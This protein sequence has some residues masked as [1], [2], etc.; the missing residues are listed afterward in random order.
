MLWKANGLQI[1]LQSAREALGLENAYMA[2]Y[3]EAALNGNIQ[4]RQKLEITSAGILDWGM[5]DLASPPAFWFCACLVKSAWRAHSPKRWGDSKIP[6]VIALA[7]R[8]C[9][10]LSCLCQALRFLPRWHGT[11]WLV[12]YLWNYDSFRRFCWDSLCL[13]GSSLLE[14]W[15]LYHMFH[16]E[17]PRDQTATW[18]VFGWEGR[19][20]PWWETWTIPEKCKWKI[21]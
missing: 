7:L 4:Q 5:G 15:P 3:I 18:T 19:C 14:S 16:P 13:R 11:T 1:L 2:L 8:V 12:Y 20:D 21:Q 6:E 9:D 10:S 17:T